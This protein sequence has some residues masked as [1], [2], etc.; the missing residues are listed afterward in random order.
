MIIWYVEKDFVF[1]AV[2]AKCLSAQ[3]AASFPPQSIN[4]M[5]PA[6]L[7]CNVSFRQF[8]VAPTHSWAQSTPIQRIKSIASSPY[9]STKGQNRL[10]TSK[11]TVTTNWAIWIP[12]FWLSA[13]GRKE[14]VATSRNKMA[15]LPVLKW[16][17]FN[18]QKCHL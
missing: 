18:T 11:T 12:T 7:M 13:W 6:G 17:I 5:Q 14:N 9:F 10:M 2:Y 4:R 1:Y 3:E 8:S 15:K 16:K